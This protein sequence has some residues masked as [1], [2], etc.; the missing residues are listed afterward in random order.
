MG[1]L[2]ASV[3]ISLPGQELLLSLAF[4]SCCDLCFL[5]SHHLPCVTGAAVLLPFTLVPS[6]KNCAYIQK[7]THHCLCLNGDKVLGRYI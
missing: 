1:G 2:S 4:L 5:D 7:E 3:R 6:E